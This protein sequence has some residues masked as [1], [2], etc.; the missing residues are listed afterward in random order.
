MLSVSLSSVLHIKARQ[1]DAPLG[2]RDFSQ[3]N[4]QYYTKQ[5][6]STRPKILHQIIKILHQTYFSSP[7]QKNFTSSQKYQGV[8]EVITQS[9]S[10]FSPIKAVF[11]AFSA[12]KMICFP[13]QFKKKYLNSSRPKQL[14]YKN[15]G[16]ASCQ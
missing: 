13:V 1:R 14:I 9:S 10:I 8:R 11:L 2:L 6:K 16:N 7:N 4:K 5:K 15:F 12:F 3:T